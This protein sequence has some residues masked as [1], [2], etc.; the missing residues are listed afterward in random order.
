[1]SKRSKSRKK[2][3]QEP[4][5]PTVISPTCGTRRMRHWKILVLLALVSLGLYWNTLHHEFVYDDDSQILNNP[6]VHSTPSIYQLFLTDVWGF[7]VEGKHSVSNYYRPLQMAS[8]HWIAQWFGIKPLPFHVLNVLFNAAV[9]LLVYGLIW[10][11]SRDHLCA[12]LASLLFAFHPMH[13]EVVNW[14]ACLPELGFTFFYLLSLLCFWLVYCQLFPPLPDVLALREIHTDPVLSEGIV[15]Q[16]KSS[17]LA[18]R[19]LFLWGGISIGSYVVA[20]LWKEMSL[21][22]PLLMVFILFLYPHYRQSWVNKFTRSLVFASPFFVVTFLYLGLRFHVLGFVSKTHF[23]WNLTVETLLLNVFVLFAD[24]WKKLFFPLHFNLW[25]LFQPVRSL[26]D[27]RVWVSALVLALLL[28]MLYRYKTKRLILLGTGWVFLTLLPVMNIEGVG[29]NVFTERYL[30]L[31]SVGFCLVVA[32][33]IRE[34]FS[35]RRPI[36]CWIGGLSG[37]M[38]LLTFSILIIKRNQDWRNNLVL[39][40]RAVKDSPQVLSFR[41]GLANLLRTKTKDLDAAERECFEA[42]RLSNNDLLD[43]RDVSNA[44]EQL[45][46]ISGERHD[47]GQALIWIEKGLEVYPKNSQLYKTRGLVYL[48]QGNQDAAYAEF[49]KALLLLPQDFESCNYM[50]ATL[51]GKGNPEQALIYIK[52]AIYINPTFADAWNNASFAY[53]VLG[54]WNR[55]LEHAKKA[56]ELSPGNVVYLV[57]AAKAANNLNRR[58]ESVGYVKEALSKSPHYAPAQELG[59][60]LGAY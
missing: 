29:L 12:T 48:F 55:S 7:L 53:G 5:P 23:N 22:L 34:W 51:L 40:T 18:R 39:Y 20:L 33:L 36:Y 58:D 14:I 42:I 26:V 47:Y 31:P 21:T 3:V 9:V 17:G 37:L 43:K 49:G 2:V 45:S 27:S 44:Y 15:K 19:Q 32:C 54:D 60:V 57:N 59:K 6:M 46:I 56:L 1:M 10:T 13:T 4:L 8:Y 11:F 28:V 50:G 41:L 35:C 16:L 25:Y 24:Y 30:Y 38:I 52:K